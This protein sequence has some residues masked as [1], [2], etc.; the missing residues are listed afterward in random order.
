MVKYRGSGY[1]R[2]EYPFI[3]GENG[4]NVIPITSNVLQHRSPGR[5][6]SSG[7]ARLDHVLAG[8]YK[9]GTSILIAGSPG[10]GKDHTG[11]R[12]RP[13]CLPARRAG[14]VS[15]FRGVARIDGQQHAEPGIV[16]APLIKTGRLVIQSYLPEAMGA[17]EHLFHALNALD[18]LHPQHVI[19]DA[20]SACKRMGSEQAAFEYLMRVLN[21]CKERGITCFYLNQAIGPDV[22]AEISGIGISSI[23]D[24]VVVLCQ[25]SIGGSMKR[26][27]IVMKSRGSKH[28]DRS[29]EYR[30]TDRG[31]EL[32][33][34]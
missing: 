19:V 10:A 14:A 25:L 31:I 11:L 5:Q 33:K 4:I 6:V 13:G 18:E 12:V 26:Q 30:I 7:Q 1:G 9:R 21:A 2:N 24:T 17:E 15:Q 3:I 16:L 34:A 8:G 28:S 32:V 20:I 29:H 23:I 22:V 27:L